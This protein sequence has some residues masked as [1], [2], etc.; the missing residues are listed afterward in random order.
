M[1]KSIAMHDD[2]EKKHY[3]NSHIGMQKQPL[4][5]KDNLKYHKKNHLKI[6]NI[7]QQEG[8]VYK[9][10]PKR[11]GNRYHAGLDKDHRKHDENKKHRRTSKSQHKT[12]SKEYEKKGR[13][14]GHGNM[15]RTA[16]RRHHITEHKGFKKTI[17]H[18]LRGHG[19]QTDESKRTI[20]S[21]LNPPYSLELRMAWTILSPNS[22]HC[23]IIILH[24][25]YN[26]YF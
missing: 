25:W 24:N 4:K 11:Q 21:V 14:I 3:E 6:S 19:K 16:H 5:Y 15:Q 7:D 23:D 2:H 22:S 17:V 12:Q 18:H 1:G 9:E 8:L 26:I 10:N 20:Y 13:N